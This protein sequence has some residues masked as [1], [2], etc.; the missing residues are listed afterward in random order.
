MSHG[1]LSAPHVVLGSSEYFLGTVL[2]VVVWWVLFLSFQ[3]SFK[4]KA[5]VFRNVNHLLKLLS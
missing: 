1:R 5:E 3:R 4:Q 2:V